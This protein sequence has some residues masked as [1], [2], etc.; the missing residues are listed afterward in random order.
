MI[1]TGIVAVGRTSGC[2]EVG[3]RLVREGAPVYD[4]ERADEM[5][6]TGLRMSKPEP[7]TLLL[8]G[9]SLVGLAALRRRQR[10]SQVVSSPG[11]PSTT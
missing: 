5:R 8:F 11:V 10:R 1:S 2:E 4:V 6:L 9:S 7:T 3:D